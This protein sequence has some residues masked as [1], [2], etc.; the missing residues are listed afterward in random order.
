MQLSLVLS[1]LSA[2]AGVSLAAPSSSRNLVNFAKR[3]VSDG[4]SGAA[5]T[6]RLYGPDAGSTVAVG[7]NLTFSYD[8]SVSPLSP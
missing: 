3:D 5:Y 1:A 2:L 4:A 7:G 6:G 8:A